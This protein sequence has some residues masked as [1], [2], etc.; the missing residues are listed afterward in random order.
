M[1]DTT[2]GFPF[3]CVSLCVSRSDPL[4]SESFWTGMLW[5]KIPLLIFS[6]A[7]FSPRNLVIFF[8]FKSLFLKDVLRFFYVKQ[9]IFA[10]SRTFWVLLEFFSI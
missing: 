10:I 3:V 7:I 9:I 4:D 5:W 1:S 6:L 8:F 2:Q